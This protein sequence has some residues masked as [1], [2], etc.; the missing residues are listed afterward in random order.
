[1]HEGQAVRVVTDST[2]DIPRDVA[3][4]LGITV[5]PMSFSMGGRTFVDGEIPMS[6]FF[7][8]MKASNTPPTTSQPP[9]GAF[10]EVFD[11]LLERCREVVCISVSGRLSG[12]LDSAIGAAR[13]VGHRVHVLD[14]RALSW[15]EGFQAIQSA[16]AAAAGA[17]V[18]EVKRAADRVRQKMNIVVGLDGLDNLARSGRIGKVSAFVGGVLNIK[19]LLTIDAEGA[20]VPIARVRGTKA[21]LQSTRDWVIDRVEASR[22]LAVAVLHAGSAENA[23]WLEDQ[24]RAQLHAEELYVIETGPVIGTHAGTG[25]GLAAVELD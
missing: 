16:R 24:V 19:V 8:R 12:T 3:E 21:A 18:D 20:L 6:E 25:W 5:V 22:R 13:L 10:V 4:A 17:T 11:R 2:A 14:S 23:R 7:A 9:V 1:M 15:A